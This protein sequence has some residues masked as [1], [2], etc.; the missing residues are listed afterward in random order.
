MIAVTGHNNLGEVW[1]SGIDPDGPAK[2]VTTRLYGR[3]RNPMYLGV[4]AAQ[5]GFFLALPS[6]FTL[7]CLMAGFAAVFSQVRL[8][9]VHLGQQFPGQYANYLQ[10][11]PRWL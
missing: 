6:A 4:L 11:V 8:E 1:R 2:L 9:E 5:L 3:S 7:V 10:N